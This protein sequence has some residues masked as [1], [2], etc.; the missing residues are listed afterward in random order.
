LNYRKIT[1]ATFPEKYNQQDVWW[2]FFEALNAFD[3]DGDGDTDILV[4]MTGKIWDPLLP[5]DPKP[6][7][8]ENLG[9]SEFKLSSPWVAGSPQVLGWVNN[10]VIGDFN[11]D[12]VN[13]VLVIDHGREDKPYE[14]RDFAPPILYLSSKDGWLETSKTIQ[15]LSDWSRPGRDF[16]H[17]AINSRDFNEDG[18]LD[19]VITALGRA[20]VELWL[21]DGKGN[22]SNESRKFLPGF[23]DRT[24]AKTDGSWTSFGITG[25][26]DAGGDGKQ[27]IF[28]LPYAFSA[29]NSNGYVV[30]N[31]GSQRDSPINLGDLAKDPRIV[32]NSNRGYSEA[33]V[34]DFDRNGLEDILAIA[35]ASNGKQ[36]GV[37]YLMY[38]SQEAPFEFFDRTIDSFGSYSSWHPQVT[39]RGMDF[40]DLFFNTASTEFY[41]GDYNGDGFMDVN[42]GFSFLGEW[43]ALGS[44]IF[45][46]NSYG[47]FSRSHSVNVIGDTSGY[48]NLR[49]DG[50]G[51]LNKDGYADFLVM[52][53]RTV[54][55]L[56][57]YDVSVLVSQPIDQP[58]IFLGT[59]L[60]NY[61]D[62]NSRNN[63]FIPHLG[64]GHID[65][66]GGIDTVLYPGLSEIYRVQ[67]LADSA[68]V[69]SISDQTKS[70]ILRSVER[71][72]FSDKA[73]ALDAEAVG[74]Q[75]Y[76][77]YKAAFNRE[78]DQGGLGYW[79]AQ[80]DSGM[81]MVEVAARFI[82]SNEFRAMYGTAPSD[83]QYLTKVY[84][85][86]LGRDPEPD[87]YNWWLN[88]MR[89]N[90][91]KTRAKVLAD[92]SE[93]T[94][95]KAGTAQL[96]G[97]G[98][99]YEPWVG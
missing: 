7:L 90:P 47:K 25:F 83:E 98:I 45:I 33:L 14:L 71:I 2:W 21:G 91:E 96:V 46:N 87:G 31:P 27:D 35:E 36:E 80:M 26:I 17:G 13:D 88:E 5:G 92:F 55:G 29:T 18:H 53:Q 78:P 16:W 49:T 73:L 68:I 84:Q 66:K 9:E 85:N 52:S 4:M 54:N 43:D 86:V 50:V 30:L 70:D 99:V 94:E 20:G 37:M 56:A 51:D 24:S 89:T 23:I 10:I 22:F 12:G 34:F 8:I 64:K 82:D 79:I 15:P 75:A 95:N 42:L 44:T 77:V 72:I 40:P 69:T 39:P 61:L 48:Q 74:G 97:Q 32:N 28:M 81:N 62:G 3:A 11:S 38:L 93:S 41:L 6:Y 60:S 19:L 57:E 1:V 63:T 76:R 65:G 58:V 67:V 59:E